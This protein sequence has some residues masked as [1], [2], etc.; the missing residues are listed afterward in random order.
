[1]KH[2]KWS[3][4]KEVE[5]RVVIARGRRV[6]EMLMKRYKVSVMQDGEVLEI[7]GTV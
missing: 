4:S 5:G 2:P 7:Y 3:N 6:G 1:M